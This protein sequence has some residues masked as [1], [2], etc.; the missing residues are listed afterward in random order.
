MAFPC[1]RGDPVWSTLRVAHPASSSAIRVGKGFE[2]Q[3]RDVHVLTQHASKN[4]QRY[5]DV[6][7]IMYGLPQDWF[8][9]NL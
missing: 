5:E 3:F 9:L 1:E 8:V 6:G 4:V 7:K 2:R